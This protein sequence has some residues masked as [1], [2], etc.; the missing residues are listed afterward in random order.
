MCVFQCSDTIS[1]FNM[2]LLPL[3]LSL[4]TTEMSLEISLLHTPLYLYK[5]W[6][7]LI[8]GISSSGWALAL[9]VSPGTGNA[10]A[11]NHDLCGSS[12]AWTTL[13]NSAPPPEVTLSPSS[14]SEGHGISCSG[15]Y[16]RKGIFPIWGAVTHPCTATPK[17]PEW[18]QAKFNIVIWLPAALKQGSKCEPWLFSH[19]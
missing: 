16:R 12:G 14:S 3:V 5:H 4:C 1:S 7:H 11:P 9:S 15:L 10:A 17:S 8:W 18:A 2:C 6:P 19:I 13:P